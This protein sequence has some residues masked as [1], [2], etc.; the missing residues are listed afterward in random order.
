[1]LIFPNF[2]EICRAG[3]NGRTDNLRLAVLQAQPELNREQIGVAQLFYIFIAGPE[4]KQSDLLGEVGYAG[5]SEHRNV[6]DVLMDEIGLRGTVDAVRMP[7]E[8][9]RAKDSKGEAVQELPL[10][11][12][13]PGWLNLEAGLSLE[14]VGKVIDSG[15]G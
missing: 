15:D 12:H 6:S 4:R 1:V 5:I 8:L 14:I 7:N 9:S 2:F 3:G 13:S 11:Y 10:I